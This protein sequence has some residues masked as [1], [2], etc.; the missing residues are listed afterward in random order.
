VYLAGWAAPALLCCVTG[1]AALPQYS[2]GGTCF[3]GPAPAAGAILLPLLLAGAALLHAALS[4]LA[5]PGG[6]ARSLLAGRP[7][8]ASSLHSQSTLLLPDTERS[9]RS[10]ALAIIAVFLLFLAALA[11]AG[12]AA[13]TPFTSVP[14]A[15]QAAL[16]SSLYSATAA[17][18]GLTVLT[19][20]CLLRGDLARRLGPGSCAPPPEET[21]NLV[22]LTELAAH[23]REAKVLPGER[24]LLSSLDTA[25][26][27]PGPGAWLGGSVLGPSGGLVKQCNVE[28]GDSEASS[29]YHSIN[30]TAH[31]R[32][33][34][35]LGGTSSSL[36]DLLGQCQASKMKINNVNIH[37]SEGLSKVAWGSGRLVTA[38][39]PSSPAELPCPSLALHPPARAPLPCGPPPRPRDR[40]RPPRGREPSSDWERLEVSSR[41]SQLSSST[42][43][44]RS[45]PGQSRW[46]GRGR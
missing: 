29:D 26:D 35:H 21:S 40:W 37:C 42:Q 15:T 22:S 27:K 20:Y 19:Y 32:R 14:V 10:Q 46:G 45:R 38:W 25:L 44:A 16:F 13:A 1:G 33:P 5:L 30:N 28:R 9:A 23:R 7:G 3:L 41:H 31:L 4:T 18:L 6:R 2:L 43:S 8:S 17:T 34:L 12:L 24:N 36:T 39:E 11:L